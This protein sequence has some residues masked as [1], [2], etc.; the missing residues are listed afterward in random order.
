MQDKQTSINYGETSN[1]IDHSRTRSK[2]MSANI[3]D[4][5]IET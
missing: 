5:V 3:I 4:E 2:L 1:S